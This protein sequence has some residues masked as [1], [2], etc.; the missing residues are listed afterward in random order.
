MKDQRYQLIFNDRPRIQGTV[1]GNFEREQTVT[2]R[3]MVTLALSQLAVNAF[4]RRVNA[5]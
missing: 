1:L 2:H 5:C 3:C 4:D